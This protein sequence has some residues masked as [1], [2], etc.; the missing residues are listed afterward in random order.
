MFSLSTTSME[1]STPHIIYV[2][3]SENIIYM[4]SVAPVLHFLSSF[5]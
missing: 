2:H 3:V 1:T 4:F 5:H